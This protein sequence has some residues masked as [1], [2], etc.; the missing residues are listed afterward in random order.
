MACRYVTK[1]KPEMASY[2][3]SMMS[4]VD[5]LE[6]LVRGLRSNRTCAR[7]PYSIFFTLVDVA[8]VAC[9][10]LF[11][12]DHYTFKR[13]LA[14]EIVMP[15]INWRKAANPRLQENVKRAMR[16]VRIQFSEPALVN[17][18]WQDR[19]AFCSRRAHR[20][21]KKKCVHS[22]K[23]ICGYRY[24]LFVRCRWTRP[25]SHS[26]LSSIRILEKMFVTFVVFSYLWI[27]HVLSCKNL[28]MKWDN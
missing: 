19:C 2:Y 15:L 5:N 26:M 6:K 11:S 24:H 25:T 3:N 7:W 22:N 14:F 1:G 28:F 20:K 12:E 27:E 16:C 13:E 4:G 10:K 9:F 18:Q 17:Q 21:T 8:V 23:F